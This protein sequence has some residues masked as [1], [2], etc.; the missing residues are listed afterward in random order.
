MRVSWCVAC[1]LVVSLGAQ[2]SR[3]VSRSGR[4]LARRAANLTERGKTEEALVAWREAAVV[5]E[6]EQRFQQAGDAWEQLAE[7]L[8]ELRGPAA[9]LEAASAGLRARER[10]YERRQHA[11][12]ARS[13]NHV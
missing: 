9:A 3:A 10:H 2:E 1:V 13:L 8:H 12:L 11:E 6:R 5:L 7:R 4:G